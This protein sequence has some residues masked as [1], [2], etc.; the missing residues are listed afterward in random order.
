[1]PKPNS[2][3]APETK[4][5]D[6]IARILGE[7]SGP[8]EQKPDGGSPSCG[9][10]LSRQGRTFRCLGSKLT[11]IVVAH[12]NSQKPARLHAEIYLQPAEKRKGEKLRG[13]RYAGLR[14]QV[15][16]RA[17]PLPVELVCSEEAQP[18]N[19]NL[20]ESTS[21]QGARTS[22]DILTPTPCLDL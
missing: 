10:H 16:E 7:A 22:H 12:E 11:A 13:F 5:G 15:P 18:S 20:R 1:M 9:G 2:T 3:E 14:N 4:K 19:C 21:L 17:Q 8:L 6:P